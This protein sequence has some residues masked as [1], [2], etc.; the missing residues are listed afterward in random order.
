MVMCDIVPNM[1]QKGFA[2]LLAIV[3][4]ASLLLIA[5]F[6]K[7]QIKTT[8]TEDDSTKRIAE[9]IALISFTEYFCF[10]TEGSGPYAYIQFGYQEDGEI[11][12]VN[13]KT[14]CEDLTKKG[15]SN[16]AS[17]NPTL[18]G[19]KITLLYTS[20]QPSTITRE[21]GHSY[22][23]EY[24]KQTR[25]FFNSINIYD[26]LRYMKNSNSS[27]L[28][29]ECSKIKDVSQHDSCISYQAAFQAQINICEMATIVSNQDLCK[30]WVNNLKTG[31]VNS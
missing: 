26:N 27:E 13:T 30:Q 29:K 19:E 2:P 23:I 25:S 20:G 9:K 22:A 4:A 3:G 11:K 28:V 15:V 10:G 31:A 7:S 16:D 17:K 18:M 24:G 12:Y 6:I 8:G 1:R 21:N 5:V 14:T